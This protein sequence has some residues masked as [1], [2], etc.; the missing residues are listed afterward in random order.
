M[1]EHNSYLSFRGVL[2][3]RY[4]FLAT[5]NRDILRHWL[6]GGTRHIVV[7]DRL[8]NIKEGACGIAL[9]SLEEPACDKRAGKRDEK[10][11]ETKRGAWF[12]GVRPFVPPWSDSRRPYIHYIGV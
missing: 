5:K 7:A 1:C 11:C 8:M 4:D 9:T 6:E 3:K 2:V 12:V 10:V